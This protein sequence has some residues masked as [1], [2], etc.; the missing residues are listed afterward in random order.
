MSFIIF[1]I[2]PIL[3]YPNWIAEGYIGRKNYVTSAEE[4]MNLLEKD[5]ELII[6]LN[7]YAVELQDKIDVLR[8]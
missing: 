1:L 8:G 2:I 7:S 4:K 5:R 6:L 3:L